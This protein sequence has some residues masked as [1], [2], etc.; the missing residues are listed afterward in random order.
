M[1][2]LLSVSMALVVAI[3]L[4]G[5]SSNLTP[6]Q[7]G[8]PCSSCDYGYVPVGKHSERRVWCIKDGKTLDCKKSPPECPECA[9][10]IQNR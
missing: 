6:E 9:R 3:G 7:R 2:Q 5:C 10:A 1:R 4:A 8:M